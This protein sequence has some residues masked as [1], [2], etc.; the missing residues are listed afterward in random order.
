M[1]RVIH[2]PETRD[3]AT[4]IISRISD[5]ST[6]SFFTLTTYYHT[7]HRRE[8]WNLWSFCVHTFI[9]ETFEMRKNIRQ[10]GQ[11][12]TIL[13][14]LS[15]IVGDRLWRLRLLVVRI[16]NVARYHH[17]FEPIFFWDSSS[18]N[19]LI[20]YLLILHFLII[21]LILICELIFFSLFDFNSTLILVDECEFL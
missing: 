18:L 13:E 12:F 6:F 3:I 17:H 7:R 15:Q 1:M 11:L 4:M 9:Q 16:V 2:P 21:R 10:C 8:T 20:W 14:E 19:K 5:C